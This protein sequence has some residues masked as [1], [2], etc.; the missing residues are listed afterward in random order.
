MT[1]EA[2]DTFIDVAKPA[3]ESGPS[4]GKG[5]ANGDEEAGAANLLVNHSLIIHSHSIHSSQSVTL[6]P[7]SSMHS[8]IHH[9]MRRK[10][11]IPPASH[12][13]SK[14]I[15]NNN[16]LPLLTIYKMIPNE[17]TTYK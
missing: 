4:V 17:N 6:L 8:C 1:A 5:W 12:V 11:V 7:S 9:L 15:L 14:T 16:N 10:H 3:D 13:C 2:E